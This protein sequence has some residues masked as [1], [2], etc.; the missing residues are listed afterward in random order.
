MTPLF[1]LLALHRGRFGGTAAVV[2]PAIIGMALLVASPLI[3]RRAQTGG[4]NALTKALLSD[5]LPV[6]DSFRWP[7]VTALVAIAI[8][9]LWATRLQRPLRT[10]VQLYAAGA[11]PAL[12]MVGV[13]WPTGVSWFQAPVVAAAEYARKSHANVVQWN[14]N[15]PSFSVY[16]GE[17]TPTRPPFA[18]TSC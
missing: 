1:L 4:A 16:R 2:A 9:A 5:V 10:D 17:A 12:L 11:I 3:V 6:F 15:W 14:S 13:L 8:V 7:A 18:E